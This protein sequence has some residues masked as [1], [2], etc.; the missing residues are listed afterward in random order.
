[1]SLT[2]ILMRHAKS[3]W[4]DPTMSDH[5]R[6]LNTRGRASAEALGKWLTSRDYLP[7]QLLSSTSERTRETWSRLGL[8]ASEIRYETALYHAS[9]DTML[10]QLQT[11]TGRSV[12]ML[13]HN[14]GIGHFAELLAQNP[15]KHARFMD[16][17]TCAT[18][19]FSF[20]PTH[21]SDV[22]FSQGAVQDFT[23]PRDL[24]E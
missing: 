13:G 20:T 15:P 14:P 18:T 22:Q 19:V 16:Y 12:L 1:M 9:A 21:W 17:P 3:S 7:D 23:T 2:L 8:T 24:L 10:R 6:P 11:A 4:D 5:D